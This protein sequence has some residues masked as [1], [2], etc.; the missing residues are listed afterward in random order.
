[1]NIK[2]VIHSSDSMDLFYCLNL[3]AKDLHEYTQS[4][5]K[6]VLTNELAWHLEWQLNDNDVCHLTFL[7]KMY[8]H[9]MV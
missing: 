7:I 8:L 1:M 3:K 5:R 6:Y 2:R 4:V 9:G